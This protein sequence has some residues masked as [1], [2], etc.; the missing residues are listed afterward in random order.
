VECC[1][2]G[3]KLS[4]SNLI[5]GFFCLGVAAPTRIQHLSEFF[6][7]ICCKLNW[8]FS[9]SLG[10]IRI[11]PCVHVVA[12]MR[13]L[14]I[15]LAISLPYYHETLQLSHVVCSRNATADCA[16]T[17]NILLLKIQHLACDSLYSVS[18][19]VIKNCYLTD[20]MHVAKAESRAL[21]FTRGYSV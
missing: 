1:V 10:R 19:G 18:T 3:L 6:Q 7:W 14:L 2:S 17:M 21:R 16:W 20:L 4:E 8:Y 15:L 13:I 9:Q 12:W 11:C 5:L